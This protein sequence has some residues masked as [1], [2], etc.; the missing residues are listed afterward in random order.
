MSITN[1]HYIIQRFSEAREYRIQRGNPYPDPERASY[2]RGVEETWS[3]IW[4]EAFQDEVDD[5]TRELAELV[6]ERGIQ[7]DEALD[8][9][10]KHNYV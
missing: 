7:Y 4:R 8:K 3:T 2:W 10:K 1:P 9:I 6:M 5:D